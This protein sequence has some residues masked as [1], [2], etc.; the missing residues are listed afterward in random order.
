MASGQQW[1]LVEM[2]QAF[3]EVS[4]SFPHFC[5]VEWF[6]GVY[7]TVLRMVRHTLV[8]LSLPESGNCKVASQEVA[9][10]WGRYWTV[11]TNRQLCVAAPCSGVVRSRAKVTRKLLYPLTLSFVCSRTLQ[12]KIKFN[13][14][15]DKN[16]L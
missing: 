4:F 15:H 8:F 13:L 16:S 11:F 14:I 6:P 1:V 2:V 10:A 5:S 9:V 3:Y 12:K 7:N